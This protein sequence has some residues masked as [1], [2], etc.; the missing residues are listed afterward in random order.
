MKSSLEKHAD[1]ID[2]VRQYVEPTGPTGFEGLVAELLQSL[3]GLRF[4]V[5]RGGLDSSSDG[6]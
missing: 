3:T 5:A 2:L 1:W 6:Q 4:R